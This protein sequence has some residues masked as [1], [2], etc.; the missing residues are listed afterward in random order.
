MSDEL[1]QGWVLVSLKEILKVEWGNTSITKKR[2][3]D[4]KSGFPAYSATGQDGFLVNYEW[5]GPAV[6]LSAIGAKCGKCFYADGKW[7]AIKNTIVIKGSERY[8]SHKLLYYYLNDDKKWNVTGSGRPFI[9]MGSAEKVEYRLAP[10]LEQH[11]IVDKLDQILAK[12]EAS[13]KRL[14]K[15]PKRLKRFRQSV[16]AS[17]CSGNLTA[18][19]REENNYENGFKGIVSEDVPHEIPD[20][21]LWVALK[22]L[23]N[24][25]HYGTSSKSNNEG[26]VPVLR[27]GNL[28]NSMIDWSSLKY[29][30]DDSEIKKYNLDAGD[31]LFN[32]TNSPE[33][34]GKT[35][36]YKG[37]KKA[38]FAGYLIR[39]KNKRNYLDSYYLNYCLNT[40]RAKEWCNQV[41][42]DGV[43]QSNINAQILASFLIPLPSPEEQQEI[44]LRVEQLFAVADKIEQRYTKA[45]KQIEK[46][47][48]SILAKAFRGE[49]VPQ[50]PNDEPAGVWLERI[51]VEREKKISKDK[52]KKEEK[53]K[54]LNM[55]SIQHQKA[56]NSGKEKTRRRKG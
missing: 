28:Q 17:A 53:N 39:I 41:K 29:T 19:W 4:N 50:D 25:F 36:I 44:V 47:T 43:S 31:V 23:S 32:R 37:E 45:A 55:E 6:I 11:R 48:Q 13:K 27:M 15:F 34:V 18:D 1:P 7:T 30:N 20:N 51:K 46:L 52:V 9:T 21:W 33:L 54:S 3:V 8:F 2:Y 22:E 49:L 5:D 14:D 12:V 38:I 16:L 42:T 24:G 56:K 35:S 10:L 26:K 40:T